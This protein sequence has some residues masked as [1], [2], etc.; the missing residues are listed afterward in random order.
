VELAQILTELWRKK[1]WV[2]LAIPVAL[3]LALS[4]SYKIEAGI[5]PKLHPKGLE[6]GAAQTQIMLDTVKSPLSDI[7]GD[8]G[9]LNSRAVIY[10]SLM[11]TDPVRAEIAKA[12]G[13]AEWKIAIEGVA[14]NT[15]RGAG[16]N[17]A[18]GPA[19][20]QV[21]DEQGNYIVLTQ[22]ESAGQQ[23]PLPLISVFTQAPTAQE[24]LKL[25]QG[26]VAGFSKYLH[27]LQDKGGV[28][29]DKRITV[30]QLGAP[31]AGVVNPTVK[32]TTVILTFLGCMFL[33]CFLILAF[34]HIRRGLREIRTRETFAYSPDQMAIFME[35]TANGHRTSTANGSGAYAGVA[36][37]GSANGHGIHDQEAESGSSD[38]DSERHDQPTA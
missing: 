19:A 6:L 22:S 4:T 30:R 25:A 34:G 37:N 5:P 32:R 9:P 17:K 18:S 11:R 12:S 20:N 14:L 27:G 36:S 29:P 33:A 26:T 7:D 21:I 23:Y 8:L 24:A 15:S 16:A 13:I 1:L 31:T 35:H 10:A 28:A 38:S 3:V 2:I